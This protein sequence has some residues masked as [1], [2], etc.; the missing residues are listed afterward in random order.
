MGSGARLLL[1]LCA[2]ELVFCYFCALRGSSSVVSARSEARPF[3]ISAR[4]GARLLLFLR[5][6]GLVC[7]YF[8]ALCVTPFG[9]VFEDVSL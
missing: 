1:L 6:L 4:S 7:C 3:V 5:V 8:S 2:L 9:V